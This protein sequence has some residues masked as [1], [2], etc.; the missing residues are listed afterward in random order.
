VGE[1]KKQKIKLTLSQQ[2]EWEYYFNDRKAECQEIS[3]QI[4]ATD[5]EIDN[6][7]FD[8]YGLTADERAIVKVEESFSKSK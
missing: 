8:L 3:A 4:K 5:N 6:R 1:L 2:D 7:V